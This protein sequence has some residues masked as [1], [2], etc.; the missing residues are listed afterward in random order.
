[1]HESVFFRPAPFAADAL[2]NILVIWAIFG[3]LSLMNF[4]NV[5]YV[6]INFTEG[7]YLRVA[8]L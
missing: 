3:M 1:M 7:N 4:S 8:A 2:P 6:F 5:Y